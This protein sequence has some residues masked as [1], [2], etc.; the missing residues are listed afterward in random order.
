MLRPNCRG[1]V[2]AQEWS[3]PNRNVIICVT[4]GHLSQSYLI[5]FNYFFRIENLLI[6]KKFKNVEQFFEILK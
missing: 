3:R 1:I 6:E 2:T 4:T 5:T